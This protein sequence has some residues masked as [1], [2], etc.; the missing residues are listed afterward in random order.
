MPN[1]R[2]SIQ[3][4][5]YLDDPLPRSVTE[6]LRVNNK[7]LLS[8]HDSFMDIASEM[9][10]WTFYETQDSQLSGWGHADNDEVHFSAPLTSIKSGLLA[11]RHEQVYSL[12]SDHAGCASFGE[13]NLRIMHSYLSDLSKAVAKAENLNA[14]YTH[15]PM[16]LVE[17]VKVEI[18]GFYNDPDPETSNDIRLYVSKHFLHEFFEKGPERCLQERLNTVAARPRRGSHL[19]PRTSSGAGAFSSGALGIWSNMQD[20]GQSLLGRFPRTGSP[21]E[22]VGAPGRVSPDIVVTTHAS[23]GSLPPPNRPSPGVPTP[24]PSRAR[25]LTVPALATPGF[26]R[27]SSRSSSP[28]PS[29]HLGDE[30]VTRSFTDPIV[31]LPAADSPAPSTHAAALPEQGHPHPAPGSTDPRDRLGQAVALEDFS[32]GF[33]RP[34]AAERKFMW[35]HVPFNNPHWVKV[36]RCTPRAVATTV[37]NVRA[38]R[39]AENSGGKPP[40]VLEPPPKRQLG[41]PTRTG[42]TC[43]EPC[44]VYPAGLRFRAGRPS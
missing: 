15:H 39:P 44:F 10:L 8:M 42:Q 7:P 30:E 33:S 26:H 34:E 35:I 25:G 36:R 14:T 22:A 19:H 13:N 20:I 12:E 17:K 32:A 41:R 21:S 3:H 40:D 37:A 16:R 18:I 24:T 1:L 38:E 27:P 5:L 28:R 29:A 4:L 31:G 23:P 6:Q 9:R 43:A 2:Y 11:S